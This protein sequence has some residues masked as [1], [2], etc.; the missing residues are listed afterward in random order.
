[1]RRFISMLLA[2]VG[3][4]LLAIHE[5][6][7]A[8]EIRY[9]WPAVNG[10]RINNACATADSLRSVTPVTVC[11]EMGVVA[12]QAC[13]STVVG[14]NCRTLVGNEVPHRGESVREDRRCVARAPRPVE[15]S[16]SVTLARCAEY[17]N[18]ADTNTNNC[19]RFEKQTVALDRAFMVSKYEIR[20]EGDVYIGDER[21]VI[22]WCR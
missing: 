14:E 9:E 1:M 11:T 7:A 8:N 16:R 3:F 17:S 18:V 2:M 20:P 19:L 21:Y 12:R 5:A 10:L 22:P 13:V 4:T 15:V 6:S